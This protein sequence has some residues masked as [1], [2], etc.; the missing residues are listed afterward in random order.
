M[1]QEKKT[2]VRMSFFQAF[3]SYI[4]LKI[5]QLTMCRYYIK[6]ISVWPPNLPDVCFT[7]LVFLLS[8]LTVTKERKERFTLFILCKTCVKVKERDIISRPC[9][10]HIKA[11]P[12]GFIKKRSFLILCL[13]K[14]DSKN[15]EPR[16]NVVSID[17]ATVYFRQRGVFFCFKFLFA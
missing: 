2:V 8:M 7:C 5:F 17:S 9:V 13:I 11:T 1:T 10:S 4:T 12:S 6:P 16:F 14:E 15:T 3:Y